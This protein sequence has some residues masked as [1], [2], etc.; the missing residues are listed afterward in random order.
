MSSVFEKEFR[1]KFKDL[2][3][4]VNHYVKLVILITLTCFLAAMMAF[5]FLPQYTAIAK[6]TV[7]D[8]SANVPISSLLVTVGALAEEESVLYDDTDEYQIETE[9][10]KGIESQTVI[11]KV[12]CAEESEAMRIVNELVENV[13]RRANALYQDYEAMNQEDKVDLFDSTGGSDT[14]L[15][16]IKALAQSDIN[17][18]LTFK[19]CSFSV[20]EKGKIEESG[21]GIT[22][23]AAIGLLAGL[24]ISF[25][26][27]VAIYAFKKPIKCSGDIEEAL[28]CPIVGSFGTKKEAERLWTN[29]RFM[30]HSDTQAVCLVPVEGAD[31]KGCGGLLADVMREAGMDVEEVEVVSG[32]EEFDPSKDQ[33]WL[34]LECPS[35]NESFAAVSASQGVATLLIVSFWSDSIPSLVET[36]GEFQLVGT[37]VIGV[38]IAK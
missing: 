14:S 36:M 12:T 9:I 19:Y 11:F 26:V 15:E 24:F 32:R 1:V 38:A 7:S 25:C 23:A 10:G 28:D 17:S 27:L 29:I 18:D 21:L 8:P 20:S 37:E 35:L 4:L 31:A 30:K 22:K 34:V 16:Y 5:F 2:I 6:I 3:L 13:S 33:D